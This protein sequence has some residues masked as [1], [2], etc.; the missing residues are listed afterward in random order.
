MKKILLAFLIGAALSANV[1]A[2]LLTPLSNNAYITVGGYDIAWAGPVNWQSN[3]WQPLDYSYQS[4]FGWAP[5]T[6][7]V[8]NQI[9]GLDAPN[10]IGN[11]YNAAWNGS[12]Y[13]DPA[14]GAFSYEAFLGANSI[15]IATPWFSNQ[16]LHIDYSQAV[17]GQAWNGLD[18]DGPSC[19]GSCN[20]A[21]ASRVHQG[22][23][24]PEPAT[25]AL[26]GL[27]LAGIGFSRRK[28]A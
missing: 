6:L 19:A 4:Q 16:H 17:G 14:T 23:Q 27:G 25:L 18:F 2:V 7:A 8:Y 22:A 21:L 24:V 5:M 3:Y 26:L 20:E 10:F 15:A 12:Q 1:Q 11:G 28:K 13:L 9:G